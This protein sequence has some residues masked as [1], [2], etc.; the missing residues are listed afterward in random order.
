MKKLILI[1]AI[2]FSGMLM[3]SQVIV[4]GKNLNEMDLEYVEIVGVIKGQPRTTSVYIDYSQ[5]GFIWEIVVKKNPV[6]TITDTNDVIAKKNNIMSVLNLMTKNGW[7]YVGSNSL[8]QTNS[9]QIRYLMRKK[10]D[11]ETE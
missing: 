6:Q 2:A 7:K 4:D 1:I 9:H 10:K 8:S 3:H 11:N 5:V